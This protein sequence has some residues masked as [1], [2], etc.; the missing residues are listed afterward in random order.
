MASSFSELLAGAFVYPFKRDGLIL[1]IAGTLFFALVGIFASFSFIIAIF[2]GGYFCAYLQ[3]I[4]QSSAQGDDGMPAWPD[5]SSFGE[6]VLQPFLQFLGTFLLCLAPGILG[7]RFGP[8]DFK[9][10]FYA[11][12]LLGGLYLPMALLTVAMHDTIAAL[13]PRIVLSSILRVPLGY[14]GVCVTLAAIVGV[15]LGMGW[16]ANSIGMP[17]ATSL[18]TGFVSLYLQVVAMRVLGLF[19]Y[20][21]KDRLKW[22]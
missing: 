18:L 11:L 15:D 4:I 7:I 8:P 17:I 5:V 12:Y 2:A 3:K 13:D 6:E 10:Y 19:Y 9:G 22:F 21:Q 1:V 16:L 14:A 20:C